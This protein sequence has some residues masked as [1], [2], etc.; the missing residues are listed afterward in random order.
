ML[1]GHAAELWEG[2]PH[3]A[4]YIAIYHIAL[5]TTREAGVTP[6]STNGVRVRIRRHSCS[7]ATK[8]V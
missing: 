1:L 4:G 8:T 2:R 3:A 6:P 7:Q 5:P